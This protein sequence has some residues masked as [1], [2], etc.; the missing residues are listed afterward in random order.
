ML[1]L[2]LLPLGCEDPPP[3]PAPVTS[4]RPT[5]SPRDVAVTELTEHIGMQWSG[6]SG[7]V[8]LCFVKDGQEPAT[9][10]DCGAELFGLVEGAWYLRSQSDSGAF[11]SRVVM[12]TPAGGGYTLRLSEGQA[13]LSWV[14]R[15][16]GVMR[17]R[18]PN[19]A[20]DLVRVW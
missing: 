18:T 19:T 2:L 7:R 8:E 13:E 12:V 15:S 17:W 20:G 10:P 9:T 11:T 14:D 16:S 4:A 1:C 3:P 5:P 6:A